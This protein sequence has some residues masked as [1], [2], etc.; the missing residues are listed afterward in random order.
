MTDSE[1]VRIYEEFAGLTRDAVI[2]ILSSGAIAAVLR[3]PIAVSL[4]SDDLDWAQDLCVQLSKHPNPT[5]RGDATLSFGH[6][7]RRL[8]KLNLSTVE[9]LY[10]AVLDA[11]DEYVLGQAEDM[12]DELWHRLRLSNDWPK[13]R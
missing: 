2:A 4:R 7:T 5:V 8:R 12:L 9:P 10:R 13:S 6:L 11:P 1:P 3:L